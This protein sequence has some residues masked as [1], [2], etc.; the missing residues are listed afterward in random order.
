MGPLTMPVA[1]H[2]LVF[3]WVEPKTCW[4]ARTDCSCGRP[5]V[6][7]GVGRRLSKFWTSAG[8]VLCSCCFSTLVQAP[9]KRT[10]RPLP[11]TGTILPEEYEK[12]YGP[13]RGRARGRSRTCRLRGA[14]IRFRKFTKF[15]V[16]SSRFGTR[17][18][19]SSRWCTPF[20]R[21]DGGVG[22]QLK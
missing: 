6:L 22:A 5:F 18:V 10:P 19:F 2:L 4:L 3:W 9:A 14:S 21:R 16:P 11:L 20:T 7:F 13:R 15:F 17:L 1:M 8:R 12:L